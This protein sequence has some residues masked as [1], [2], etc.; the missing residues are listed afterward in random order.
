MK[1]GSSALTGLAVLGMAI[2]LAAAVFGEM[3]VL[4]GT[5]LG[6]VY[7]AIIGVE[8][9]IVML[10]AWYIGEAMTLRQIGGAGLVVVGLM[11]VNH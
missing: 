6:P 2:G 9:L 10:Y 8:S 3:P 5:N 1:M 11:M 4:R 7:I